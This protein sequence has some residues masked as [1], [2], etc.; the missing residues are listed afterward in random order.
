MIDNLDRERKGL[1]VIK[2]PSAMILTV[3]CRLAKSAAMTMAT[4]ARDGTRTKT[5]VNGD[6]MLTDRGRWI[7]MNIDRFGKTW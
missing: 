5:E 3:D 4:I 7:L 2:S 6:L 1:P